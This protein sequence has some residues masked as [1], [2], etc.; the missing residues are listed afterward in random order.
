MP[1]GQRALYEKNNTCQRAFQQS[2]FIAMSHKKY[3]QQPD[4]HPICNSIKI[5]RL[6]STTKRK[7]DFVTTS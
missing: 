2:S 6:A 4:Y 7:R 5:K 3:K 1:V